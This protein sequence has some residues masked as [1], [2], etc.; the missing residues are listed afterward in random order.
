MKRLALLMTMLL[1]CY[2]SMAEG[3]SSAHDLAAYVAAVNE[4]EDTT[5]WMDKQGVVYLTNDIDMAKV[6]NLPQIESYDGTFDGRGFSL[7]NWKT[8]V[9]LFRQI[10]QYGKVVNLV[11]DSSCAMKC[12]DNGQDVFYAGFIA[13]INEGIIENCV[14]NGNISHKSA[15]SVVS[16]YV[17][18]I[19]GINKYLIL[20]CTNRGTIYSVGSFGG[21]KEDRAARLC[22]GGIL[23]GSMDKPHPCSFVGYCVN[24]GAVTCNASFPTNSVGG[25]VGNHSRS[26]IKY[27]VNRGSVTLAAKLSIDS[28]VPQNAY[29]G[30]ICG[31][32]N[33]DIV[34][35]D[36]FGEVF[37][38]STIY[39]CLGGIVGA[40]HNYWGLT[41]G[42]C[43]NFSPVS[44]S[45]T[46][47][48]AVGGI[49]GQS[50][51]SIVLAQCHNVADVS[52]TGES[53]KGRT[54]VG[55]I[56]GNLFVR[57]NSK[58]AATISECSNDGN[59]YCVQGSNAYADHRGMFA[60][61]IAGYIEA[62]AIVKSYV[63]YCANTGTV[64]AEGGT[65]S[66]IVGWLKFGSI[67]ECENKG[68]VSGEALYASG[69]CS[70]VEST[71][72]MDCVNHA[73][74]SSQGKGHAGGI[75][76]RTLST[77]PNAIT[78]CRNSGAIRG[79]FGLAASILAEGGNPSDTVDDCGVGGA[80]GTVSQNDV[81]IPK[82][83]PDNFQIFITGRN[84]ERNKAVIGGKKQCYYWNGVK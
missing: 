29:G 68:T 15:R 5:R 81:D 6:K 20:H 37:S 14:N 2:A 11:I 58:Y 32:T 3:I 59:V 21:S 7:R 45:G 46:A 39:T 77:M 62:N 70:L 44:C 40:A 71:A 22:M 84:V 10:T 47:G 51:R 75:A 41:V 43:V 33:S 4:G 42:D 78:G 56:A 55:G 74:I 25:I 17:G 31:L 53:M 27:C 23:G 79:R 30:G 28:G 26:K 49:L 8:E 24:E 52:F 69:I 38:R 66:G 73:D 61:G 13:D 67:R 82:V 36:N 18:G 63:E 35:S 34:C 57:R 83:N 9:G 76:A 54:A 64:T 65:A 60:A 72:I 48:A 12:S 16:N 80:V 50:S 1:G 19:C